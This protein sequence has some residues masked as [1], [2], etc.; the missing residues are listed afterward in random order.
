MTDGGFLAASLSQFT[1]KHG[2]L[3]SPAAITGLHSNA[4]TRQ[5]GASG[6]TNWK[7]RR[8]RQLRATASDWSSS[9]IVY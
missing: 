9:K 8:R 3:S 7:Q 2:R 5:T 6:A 4:V 1:G